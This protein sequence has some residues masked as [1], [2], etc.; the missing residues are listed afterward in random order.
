[1][2]AYPTTCLVD[3]E[4]GFRTVITIEEPSDYDTEMGAI[5][6][7]RITVDN[8]KTIQVTQ[9]RLS[10]EAIEAIERRCRELRGAPEDEV[11]EPGTVVAKVS[12][13]CCDARLEVQAGDD[14]ES[15]HVTVSQGGSPVIDDL[16]ESVTRAEERAEKLAESLR[17]LERWALPSDCPDCAGTGSQPPH[18]PE[19]GPCETCGGWTDAKRERDRLI[20]LNAALA[21]RSTWRPI[22]EAPSAEAHARCGGWYLLRHDDGELCPEHW[23]SSLP[24]EKW[25][26]GH[27][28]YTPIPPSDER[29][30]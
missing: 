18:G 11:S 3:H 6:R 28:E 10:L 14:D 9:V 24:W 1:M 23:D 7:L 29:R 4:N 26:S 20:G 5:A 8:V 2:T 12:C 17:K 19:D 15:E 27:R 22:S 30:G 13:P 16:T 25:S 21:P